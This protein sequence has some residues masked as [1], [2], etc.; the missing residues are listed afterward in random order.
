MTTEPAA[1]VARRPGLWKIPLGTLALGVTGL[2][3]F[4]FLL[5]LALRS[6]PPVQA[7]LVNYLWPLFIVVLSPLLLPGMVLRPVHLI[8][9]LL[10]FAGAL[11]YG[12]L[13]WTTRPVVFSES[14]QLALREEILVARRAI[15]VEPDPESLQSSASGGDEP[16]QQRQVGVEPGGELR[17]YFTAPNELRAGDSVALQFIFASSRVADTAPFDMLWMMG[18]DD[19]PE[20]HTIRKSCS[21]GVRHSIRVPVEVFEGGKRS[22]ITFRNIENERPA[23]IL[24]SANDGARIL[25]RAGGFVMNYARSLLL[26]FARLAFFSALGLAAGA[27]F[28][29]PVAAFV[30]LAFLLITGFSDFIETIAAAEPGALWQQLGLEVVPPLWDA[31]IRHSFAAVNLILPPLSKYDPFDAIEAGELISW[32]HVASAF[33]VLAAAYSAALALLSGWLFSRRELGLPS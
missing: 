20:R 22:R 10:G 26:L 8:A 13:A 23:Y 14:D 3:G 2:F 18:P 7:N 24:F 12:M 30:S 6:A 21:A 11:V 5:F 17:W 25:V 31:L 29:F 15:T 19:E 27:L 1:L 32:G 4:H 33:L 28:S 9:A 16:V